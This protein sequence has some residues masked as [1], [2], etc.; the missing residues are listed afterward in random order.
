MLNAGSFRQELAG[1]L[2]SPRR[3]ACSDAQLSDGDPHSQTGRNG[4]RWRRAVAS[5]VLA[6]A[7]PA[8]HPRKGDAMRELREW[9]SAGNWEHR[10]GSAL[11]AALGAAA[12]GVTLLAGCEASAQA[13]Q[14]DP[15]ILTCER[16]CMSVCRAAGWEGGVS[17]NRHSAPRRDCGR[18]MSRDCRCGGSFH[19]P[20][21]TSPPPP[22]ST[23]PSLATPPPS[24]PPAGSPQPPLP[25]EVIARQA[26]LEQAPPHLLGCFPGEPGTP[27]R[28][29][30]VVVVTFLPSGD[31]ASVQATTPTADSAHGAALAPGR[32]C[33]ERALRGVHSPPLA[34][35]R[36]V[37]VH[38]EFR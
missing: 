5:G 29:P 36:P 31:V 4:E 1:D 32:A 13:V 20:A 25:P 37:L 2:A 9:A 26:L 24:G 12:F 14:P 21:P 27:P 22:P 15:N 7:S 3:S 35:A 23:P 18:R 8:G 10:G 16:S 38:Y 34:G 28:P 11:R 17:L 19:P 6:T 33:L 30:I